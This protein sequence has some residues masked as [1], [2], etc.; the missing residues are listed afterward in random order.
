MC[1]LDKR[2][3]SVRTMDS[4]TLFRDLKESRRDAGKRSIGLICVTKVLG[5]VLSKLPDKFVI[6]I[7]TICKS[8]SA[9]AKQTA[10]GRQTNM[11]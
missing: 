7:K 10:F 9:M 8:F 1:R 6:L 3:S 11:K 2:E 5:D 4:R